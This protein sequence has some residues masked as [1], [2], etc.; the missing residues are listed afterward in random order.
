MAEETP[1]AVL[2]DS[3][4]PALD[5]QTFGIEQTGQLNIANRD[6]IDGLTIIRKCEARDA[7][8]ARHINAPWWAFWR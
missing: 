4:D 2:R 7:A 5:A 3:G 1:S 8:A 6:K